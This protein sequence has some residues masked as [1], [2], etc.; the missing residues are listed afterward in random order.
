MRCVAYN[1]C[2][3]DVKNSVACKQVLCAFCVL[4]AL[5]VVCV[6]AL[7]AL[8]VCAR[9]EILC[10]SH[11]QSKGAV[12]HKLIVNAAPP[13]EGT[14]ETNVSSLYFLTLGS[15]VVEHLLF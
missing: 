6:R 4:C 10:T 9:G 8:C 1:M 3:P 14:S 7:C 11:S 12:R 2:C 13:C 5:C 15:A